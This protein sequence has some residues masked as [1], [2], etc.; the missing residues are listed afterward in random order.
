MYKL[1]V[2]DSGFGGLSIVALLEQYLDCKSAAG[3][4]E[5]IYVN[6]APANEVG[7]NDLTDRVEKLNLFN[8][9]LINIQSKLN[10]DRVLIAC[11][12][13]SVFLDEILIQEN[14]AVPTL[15]VVTEGT[16]VIIEL[17]APCP[18][19]TLL[20]FA[21]ETTIDEGRYQKRLSQFGISEERL[22]FQICPGL[23]TQIS[24]DLRGEETFNKIRVFVEKAIA[25]VS[26]TPQLAAVYLGCTHYSFRENLFVRALQE[27]GVAARMLMPN[28]RIVN[29]LV[30]TQANLFEQPQPPSIRFISRYLLPQRE[31]QTISQF[32]APTAPKTARALCSYEYIKDFF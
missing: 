32:L 12:T 22:F 14:L 30:A 15:D 9:V 26:Q 16:K 4:R 5:I 2:T 10:P 7:Y 19:S 6:A 29:Q 11:N 24:N 17:L 28:L 25:K 27:M 21:T 31:V 20:F 23:A 8:Q 18:Q 13:L 1:V 3:P